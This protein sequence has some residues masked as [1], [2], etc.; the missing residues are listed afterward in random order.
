M[1]KIINMKIGQRVI[2]K[3]QLNLIKE[4]LILPEGLLRS[5]EK[6]LIFLLLG[7]DNFF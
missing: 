4:E 1:Q 3:L 2:R 5:I 7:I 6:K